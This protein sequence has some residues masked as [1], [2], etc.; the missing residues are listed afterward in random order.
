MVDAFI[1]SG[2]VLAE[3]F[4]ESH[5]TGPV[6]VVVPSGVLSFEEYLELALLKETCSERALSRSYSQTHTRR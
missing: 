4:G 1:V 3:A 2:E 5:P 6:L